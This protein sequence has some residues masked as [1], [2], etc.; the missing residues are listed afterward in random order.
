MVEPVLLHHLRVE[1]LPF[2]G[3]GTVPTQSVWPKLGVSLQA[4][5]GLPLVPLHS[6]A[7]LLQC[8]GDDVLG[9]P[10]VLQLQLPLLLLDVPLLLGLRVVLPEGRRVPGQH[11]PVV[12]LLFWWH[13]G[14][15]VWFAFRMPAFKNLAKSKNDKSGILLEIRARDWA[16]Y[17]IQIQEAKGGGSCLILLILFSN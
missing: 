4:L 12:A 3:D 16:C 2:L 17:S 15:G 5:L 8:L 14:V 13:G 9:V 10:V 1:Q 6:G 11:L 7:H